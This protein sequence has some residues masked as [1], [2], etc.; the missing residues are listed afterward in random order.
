MAT[1]LAEADMYNNFK[2]L[3]VLLSLL[4]AA[5]GG[6][7]DDPAPAAVLDTVAPY[8]SARSPTDRTQ[9]PTNQL[10]SIT[11]T[12]SE[13]V[14]PVSIGAATIVVKPAPDGAAIAGTVTVSDDGKTLTF[15]P[16]S[17]AT[18]LEYSKTYTV[19]IAKSIKDTAGNGLNDTLYM[20]SFSTPNIYTVSVKAEGLADGTSVT[21]INNGNGAEPLTFSTNTK[22]DFA[23]R[24]QASASYDV[25][26][27]SNTG[28]GQFC[29]LSGA[30]GTIS[31]N[32]IVNLVCSDVV[33]YYPV[34]GANWNDYVDT[35]AA[36]HSP[37]AHDDN[38][39]C[40]YDTAP[41]GYAS[42]VHGGELRAYTLPASYGISSCN[43]VTA[44]DSA[45]AFIW[46][47]EAAGNTV[48]MASTGL[49]DGRGLADLIDFDDLTWKRLALTVKYGTTTVTTPSAQW[50]NN[51]IT[52]ATSALLTQADTAKPGTVYV[53][54][55]G[56]YVQYQIGG[57]RL[58]LVVRPGSEILG[59]PGASA[60]VVEVMPGS[61]YTWVEG[62]INAN[63]NTGYGVKINTAWF[64]VLH[65][66]TARG[67]G[68]AG[69]RVVSLTTKQGLFPSY[70]LLRHVRADNN[71]ADGISIEDTYNTLVDVSASSNSGA[72]I[73]LLKDANVVRRA[74]AGNNAG[75]GITVYKSLNNTLS[76]ISS[77]NNGAHG[78][79]LQGS[80]SNGL[81]LVTATSNALSG[82]T[83]S[84]ADD[85]TAT[86]PV[87]TMNVLTAITAARNGAAGITLD[88]GSDGNRLSAIAAVGNA[89]DG[90]VV[91]S[92]GN[93]VSD[94][95]V[96]ANGSGG[97][98][99]LAAD[100]D[101]NNYSGA[102]DGTCAG[103]YC[104]PMTANP[105]AADLE[106][107]FRGTADI[108]NRQN[109]RPLEAAI[110][111]GDVLDWAVLDNLHQGWGASVSALTSPGTDGTGRCTSAPTNS[112]VLCKLWDWS[113]T[114]TAPV[115]REVL[116]GT[117]DVTHTWATSAGTQ[118]KSLAVHAVE[119]IGDGLGNDDTLCEADEACLYTPN[120]GSYQG[121]LAANAAL[122]NAT[123]GGALTGVTLKRYPAA[124]NGY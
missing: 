80:S 121:H 33:P 23:T 89:A 93:D 73:A 19:T 20:W 30:A 26:I 122:E 78:I 28:A 60:N 116:A 107:S 39:T 29:A 74:I 95:A 18:T 4:L 48:R 14:D 111:Y 118:I 51:P 1:F 41:K 88:P 104:P 66:V 43:G 114:N 97:G 119:I 87:S 31:G 5:C 54:V 75:S 63:G 77:F 52:L 71:G 110:L 72:G 70:S 25:A 40:Y 11:V 13:A 61:E 124:T 101:G 112:V 35:V 59:S 67:A 79:A 69:V 56:N 103:A 50:W 8:I 102:V 53:A 57:K 99:G 22:A 113:L 36:A 38:V 27:A 10:P 83:I 117:P 76:E 123:Y 108:S 98:T 109:Y 91:A 92:T 49:K 115:L 82:V 105:S 44:S 42:C 3:G 37:L 106:A 17:G 46:T 34:H 2:T 84:Q 94:I 120:I 62:A 90:M 96:A 15:T 32:V 65:D 55:T 64:T 45:D 12:L 7:N 47:C 21:L 68:K 58:A 81:A 9:L 24:L 6:A 100:A 16:E 86:P 85:G